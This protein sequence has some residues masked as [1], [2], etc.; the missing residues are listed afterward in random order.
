MINGAFCIFY[1]DD[2]LEDQQLFRDALSEINA[3]LDLYIQNDGQELIE[4]LKNPPPKPQ[5]VFLDLNM[6]RKNGL[7]ALQ[8]LRQLKDLRDLP[9]VIFTT[10][11]D[12]N[13]IKKARDF[14]ASIFITKPAFF[15]SYK[16]IIYHCLTIDWQHFKP[17]DQSFVLLQN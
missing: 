5:I 6:P 11:D 4:Q 16:K 1:A 8:E 10:S 17:S 7:Q 2:D 9:V 3:S 12:Q 15:S 13:V 14:G